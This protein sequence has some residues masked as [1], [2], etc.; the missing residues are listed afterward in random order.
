MF[1]KEIFSFST[2]FGPLFSII[3]NYLLLL[4]SLLLNKVKLKGSQQRNG[5]GLANRRIKRITGHQRYQ[6]VS[7]HA[8]EVTGQMKIT[9]IGPEHSYNPIIYSPSAY[10]EGIIT[11]IT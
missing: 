7:L 2:Y 6:C 9:I 5:K 8:Y 11:S 4:E 3:C 10:T 1:L